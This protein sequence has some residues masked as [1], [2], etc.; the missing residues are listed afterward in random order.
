MF[1]RYKKNGAEPA[2]PVIPAVKAEPQSAAAAPAPEVKP[3]LRKPLPASSAQAAPQ[4]KERKRKER[5][6]EI[7]LEMHRSLLDNLNLS[8]LETASE[9]ELRAEIGA[10][11]GEVLEERSII[12]N[13]EDRTT[14]VQELYDEVRGLGPLETLLKDDTVND[15]LVNGPH[16]IFVER[17]GKLQ[18]SDVTFKDERHLL[19]IID[20]IVSAVG[21]RVDESNPYVDARLADG[22]RFNAMVPPVAVDGSLVSIRKFKKDKLGIDDLVK[23]GAFSEEMAAYLQAAVATRLNVIV[24][25]GT[26]SGKTTTLNA[27]SSFIDNSERIL[28]IE[29]T[30]EL[31]LQ[32][33]HVGRMESRPPNVEGKGEVSPRDC[34]KNALRMRP[35]RIIVGE[36][37]GE[38][39]IDMLQAMN[40]GH[41]GS[42]TTIHANNPRD[43]ISRLEN[44]VAMAG[45]EMPLKAVR[46]QISSAV[47]LL[48][49]A[50]RLQDGSRRM[51][52]IT[53]ITGMEGDV[54][55]MQEVFRFQRV[56]LTPDNKIIGHF[57]A[58]GVRS[59]YSERFRLWGYDLPPSIYEPTKAG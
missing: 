35:D 44:M 39:V 12:L 31:Q 11:T 14:L 58:T 57:T 2:K 45:M 50:S 5:L 17:E 42:M 13:R 37:R 32:Q 36:T 6:G 28:T 59:A 48:V 33:T 27:L 22:S 29:D 47:N 56:G 19:R 41:D 1:S 30:A 7:K 40:T 43:G 23:F 54:I 55:S 16:Q 21:R 4:D 10:I 18:L 46:S 49:Q 34:L 52:S 24:S 15:I 20:K 38:E 9:A 25:G 8:A 3:S 26:G 51:T 53:E